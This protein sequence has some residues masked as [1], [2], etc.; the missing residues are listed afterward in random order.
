VLL[1][2]PVLELYDAQDLVHNIDASMPINR[3]Y[4]EIDRVLRKLK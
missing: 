4:E 1:T 3:V 2:K